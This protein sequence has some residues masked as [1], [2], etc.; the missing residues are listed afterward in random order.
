MS[1]ALASVRDAS[2]VGI[3]H[4]RRSTEAL[5]DPAQLRQA[6]R[7]L[8][9]LAIARMPFGGAMAVRTGTAGGRVVIEIADSGASA[10]PEAGLALPLAQRLLAAQGGTLELSRTPG[11]GSRTRLTLPAPPAARAAGA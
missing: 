10:G 2:G 8:L 11:R 1:E 6:L 7:H 9:R 5:A 3:T 4:E